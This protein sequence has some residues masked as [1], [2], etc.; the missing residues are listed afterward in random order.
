IFLQGLTGRL[1]Q[2]FGIVMAG[3]VVI[4]SFVSL[5]L[6]PMM[7]SRLLRNKEKEGRFFKRTERFFE[8]LNSGYSRTLNG[9]MHRRWLGIVIA[10]VCIAMIFGLGSLL[11]SELAPLED[12]SR[13][14]IFATAP[15]G[16]SFERMNEYMLNLVNVV[17]TM[18][19]RKSILSVTSPGFGSS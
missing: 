10:V 16:T 9:F 5:S 7:S 18:P 2:E 4:S 14:R 15:E 17:D 12:K 1:F 13:L 6:T 8:K 11:Q 3:A 19:E